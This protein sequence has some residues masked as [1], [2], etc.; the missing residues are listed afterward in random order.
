ME[1]SNYYFKL[2]CEGLVYWGEWCDDIMLNLFKVY[3]VVQDKYF[4]R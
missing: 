2:N 1:E 3:K 4:S